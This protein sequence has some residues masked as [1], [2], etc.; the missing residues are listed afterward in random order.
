MPASGERRGGS[1]AALSS[2]GLE[3]SATRAREGCG[4][5]GNVDKGIYPVPALFLARQAGR[6]PIRFTNA[7]S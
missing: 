3:S 6:Q 5:P 2:G 7:P 1:A 4:A